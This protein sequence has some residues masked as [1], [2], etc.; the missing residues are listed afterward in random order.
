MWGPCSSGKRT[1]D[2]WL[3]DILAII[4]NIKHIYSNMTSFYYDVKPKN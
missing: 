3:A 1:M 4:L 2:G